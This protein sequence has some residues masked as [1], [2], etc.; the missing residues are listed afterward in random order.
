M[1][2]HYIPS[3]VFLCTKKLLL[4]GNLKENGKYKGI[5]EGALC[6]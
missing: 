4:G 2:L 6:S 5:K 1:R 3:F